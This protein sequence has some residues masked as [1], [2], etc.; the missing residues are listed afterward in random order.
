M[1][2]SYYG[3]KSSEYFLDEGDTEESNMHLGIKVIG[4]LYLFQEMFKSKASTR[5]M[6]QVIKIALNLG[7]SKIAS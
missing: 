4:D 7:E 2:T 3:K 6:T 5:F 1:R